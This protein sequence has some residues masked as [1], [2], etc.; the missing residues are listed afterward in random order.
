MGKGSAVKEGREG[1]REEEEEE[2][3][4]GIVVDK[5]RVGIG[6]GDEVAIVGG[7]RE[8]RSV[9]RAGSLRLRAP[10][11]ALIQT[12]RVE[13]TGGPYTILISQFRS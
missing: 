3:E 11:P 2:E 5:R 4:V 13:C 12:N 8:L 1:E 9:W 7:R 6:E 10:A